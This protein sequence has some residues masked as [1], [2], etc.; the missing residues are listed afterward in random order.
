MFHQNIDKGE[1]CAISFVSKSRLVNEEK[2]Q[3]IQS[4]WFGLKVFLYFPTSC[5]LILRKLN[6]NNEKTYK[7][8]C[9]NKYLALN[10][11]G[12]EFHS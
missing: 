3:Y 5:I 8:Y 10:V 2:T 11:Y 4:S 12:V 6:K 7:Q 9:S 1:C